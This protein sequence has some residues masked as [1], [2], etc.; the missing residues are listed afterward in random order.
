MLVRV[1][2]GII[3]YVK[4]KLAFS[5]LTMFL[6]VL[7]E[8]NHLSLMNPFLPFKASAAICQLIKSINYVIGKHVYN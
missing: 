5:M 7:F 6:L 4:I 8:N 2:L 3:R 1:I